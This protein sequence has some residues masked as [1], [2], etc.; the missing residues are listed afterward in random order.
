[1][2]RPEAFIIGAGPAGLLAAHAASLQGWQPVILNDK[3]REQS[4]NA[5]GVFIHRAIPFITTKESEFIVK[6][7]HK[8]ESSGYAR[9]VYGDPTR[10]TSFD[11]LPPFIHAW[12][13]QEVYDRLWALYSDCIH[14][15]RVSSVM[16]ERLARTE[17]VVLNTAPKSAMCFAVDHA[18]PSNPIYIVD[19]LPDEAT[20]IAGDFMMY[21]GDPRDDWYRCSSL[22]GIE[23][24]EFAT[25]PLHGE[26]REGIKVSATNCNCHSGVHHIGRWGKW[27]PGVLLHHAFEDALEAIPA[28]GEAWS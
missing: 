23:A 14:R 2:S 27:Q 13:V 16:L 12:P 5:K 25:R 24:T 8:G 11:S 22:A 28:T 26:F 20:E 9:K 19:G 7:V 21:N 10:R 6:M 1:M 17:K 15:E 4:P 3:G 18:F